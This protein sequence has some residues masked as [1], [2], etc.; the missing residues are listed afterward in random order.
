M[1]GGRCGGRELTG[2]RRRVERW[3]KAARE[4]GEQRGE[5]GAGW[6]QTLV[7]SALLFCDPG[8]YTVIDF[9]KQE[10]AVCHCLDC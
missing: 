3:G 8:A 4:E 9:K 1:G 2:R 6:M 10:F 7:A 5:E